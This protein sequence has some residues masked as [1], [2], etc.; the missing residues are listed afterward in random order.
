MKI[1]AKISSP[2]FSATSRISV[3]IPA[4]VQNVTTNPNDR[5][6]REKFLSK[7]FAEIV[8]ARSFDWPTV[9][10][11]ILSVEIFLQDLSVNALRLLEKSEQG[12][13]AECGFTSPNFACHV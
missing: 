6:L 13:S 5:R 8:R 12:Y 2:N 7:L 11:C 9:A 4:Q 1:R 10:F 3:R